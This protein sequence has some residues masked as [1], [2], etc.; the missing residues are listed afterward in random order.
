MKYIEKD[1]KKWGL[2]PLVSLE[3]LCQ[4]KENH[5][6]PEIVINHPCTGE[7][8]SRDN[9]YCLEQIKKII[10]NNPETKFWIID[11][12]KTRQKVIG[13]HTN[14]KYCNF[15]TVSNFYGYFLKLSKN[16]KNPKNL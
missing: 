15:D 2:N 5:K 11:Y 3:C 10:E 13:D 1:L 6:L 4:I 16:Q 12:H 14:L 7:I 8:P 9:K